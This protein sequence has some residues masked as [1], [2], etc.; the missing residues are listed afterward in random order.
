MKATPI[1]PA[2]LLALLL[3]TDCCT[4]IVHAGTLLTTILL[5]VIRILVYHRC[6]LYEPA[7]VDTFSVHS[8]T[9]HDYGQIRQS[10]GLSLFS[11]LRMP[12]LVAAFASVRAWCLRY[13]QLF[14]FNA[15][16]VRSLS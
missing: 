15:A 10:S 5:L 13:W 16:R 1:G 7:R 4:G 14:C 8:V 9:C 6:I 3:S 2:E 12:K 11:A